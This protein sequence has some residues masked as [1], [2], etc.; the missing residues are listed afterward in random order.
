MNQYYQMW[1]TTYNM[2]RSVYQP[3][4]KTSTII[5]PTTSYFDETFIENF[6]LFCKANDCLPDILNWHEEGIPWMA[7]YKLIP[8]H[9]AFIRSWMSANG[10]NIPRIG[11]N[12]TVPG[13]YQNDPGPN[14]WFAAMDEQAQLDMG[15]ETC[16]SDQ[17]P[18]T[19]NCNND[20]LCG[21]LDYN[22]KQPK[23]VWYADEGYANVTGR[24]LNATTNG[25]SVVAIA[26]ADPPPTQ[27]TWCWKRPS[28]RQSRRLKQLRG[29]P[30]EL[31][32]DRFGRGYRNV[33]LG[34]NRLDLALR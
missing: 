17:L 6:L 34:A 12:E 23:S 33:F 14:V 16:N 9:V 24:L 25:A 26:G 32:A 22:T 2:I 18:G 13:Q 7:D 27:S 4:G 30:D 11:T 10:I 21:R 20:S 5:G 15:S 19:D 1:L 3:Y 31:L 28:R 29:Q 8:N